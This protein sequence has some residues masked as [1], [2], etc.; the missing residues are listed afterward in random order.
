M[1]E[2]ENLSKIRE[3]EGEMLRLGSADMSIALLSLSQIAVL[4]ELALSQGR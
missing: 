2:K 4:S 3:P 1:S